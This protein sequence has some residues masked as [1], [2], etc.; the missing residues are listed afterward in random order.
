MAL[1]PVYANERDA[2]GLFKSHSDFEGGEGGLIVR[3]NPEGT[4]SPAAG[5]QET[6]RV[7]Y[8]ADA[9]TNFEARGLYGLLD[10]Q[11]TRPETLFGSFLSPNSDPI[12]IGPATHL[13][14]G[15]VSIWQNSG[16]FMTDWFA[17]EF[18]DESSQGEGYGEAANLSGG[19]LMLATNADAGTVRRG[20]LCDAESAAAL[21][22]GTGTTRVRFM[23]MVDDT[24][25]LLASLVSPAPRTGMF[26]DGPRILLFQE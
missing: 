18:T 1:F 6:L 7:D 11:M 16:Y 15:R 8:V 14:S 20:T 10:E 3:L 19:D 26:R 4:N 5:T 23:S 2:V 12:G 17:I 22:V 13:S 25:D 9:G 21:S 24:R